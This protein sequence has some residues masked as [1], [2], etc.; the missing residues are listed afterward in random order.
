MKLPAMIVCIVIDVSDRLSIAEDVTRSENGAVREL[1]KRPW[2]W[3][4]SFGLRVTHLLLPNDR[5]LARQADQE[6]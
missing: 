3:Q 1:I 5:G 2:V 4:F 6:R